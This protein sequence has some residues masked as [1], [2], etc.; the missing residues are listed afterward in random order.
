[1]GRRSV[2]RSA[3]G[4]AGWGPWWASSVGF[5]VGASVGSVVDGVEVGVAE[6]VGVGV[7]VALGVA[8]GVL[9]LDDGGFTTGLVVGVT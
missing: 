9:T 8:G 7:G 2:V 3:S 6:S 5:E 1:M 4:W